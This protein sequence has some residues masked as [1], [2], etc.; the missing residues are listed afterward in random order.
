MLSFLLTI[1]SLPSDAKKVEPNGR[2]CKLTFAS[3][4]NVGGL[5][6][7]VRPRVEPVSLKADSPVETKGPNEHRENGQEWVQNP[8]FCQAFA[9]KDG[10]DDAR[11]ILVFI[12]GLNVDA[13]Q[14]G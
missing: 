1:S 5:L 7:R 6:Q 8:P 3:N 4:V 11:R 10:L 14:L 2:V 13:R 9:K 12:V